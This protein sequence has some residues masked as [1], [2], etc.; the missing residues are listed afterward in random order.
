MLQGVNNEQLTFFCIK[1]S[2]YKPY[3]YNCHHHFVTSQEKEW[4]RAHTIR[5]YIPHCCWSSFNVDPDSAVIA[6]LISSTHI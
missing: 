1:L 3:H 6:K 4:L 5:H 2:A